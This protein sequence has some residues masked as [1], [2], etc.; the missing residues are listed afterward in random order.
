MMVINEGH[1]FIC[2]LVR[3]LSKVMANSSKSIEQ[4]KA[5]I[6]GLLPSSFDK[7][8][9]EKWHKVL[10]VQIEALQSSNSY[11]HALTKTILQN[12][13]EHCSVKETFNFHI[14]QLLFQV[15]LVI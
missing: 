15:H 1:N 9:I 5:Y 8:G 11:D 4:T 10:I 3:I 2:V 14:N 12:A 7:E 6:R 13:A